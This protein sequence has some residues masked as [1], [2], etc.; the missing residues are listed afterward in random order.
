MAVRENV[1]LGY[2]LDWANNRMVVNHKF[3]SKAS[4]IGSEE[5]KLILQVQNDFPSMEVC[6]ESG[7][8]YTSS[9]RSKGLTYDYMR[10]VLSM[11]PDGEDL[12][13]EF[14]NQVLVIPDGRHRYQFAKDWFIRQVPDY[15]TPYETIER[16]RSAEAI[17]NRSSYENRKPAGKFAT[18]L[19]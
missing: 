16:I 9:N 8:K 10:H 7:R 1:K 13:K 12:L 18:K 2:R 17:A 3:M 15:K 4:Q 6:E 14:N 11:L 19:S 5:Y